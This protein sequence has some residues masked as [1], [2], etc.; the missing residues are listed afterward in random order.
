MSIAD[1]MEKLRTYCFRC[2]YGD[3]KKNKVGCVD[4]NH[5]DCYDNDPPTAFVPFDPDMV[6]N[7]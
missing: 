5:N 3:R 2:K 7:K 1:Y 6:L 4:A